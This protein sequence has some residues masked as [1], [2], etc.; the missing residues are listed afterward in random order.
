MQLYGL[1]NEMLSGDVYHYTNPNAIL[2]ILKTNK[3]NTGTNH[4][5]YPFQEPDHLNWVTV[6]RVAM[7]KLGLYLTVVN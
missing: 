4:S 6:R 1:L 5:F 7:Q 2:N 3:I